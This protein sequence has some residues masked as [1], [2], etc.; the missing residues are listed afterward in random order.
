MEETLKRRKKKASSPAS[1]EGLLVSPSAPAKDLSDAANTF[2]GEGEGEGEPEDPSWRFW[3][4]VTI[5][6]LFNGMFVRTYFSA[7]EFYQSTEVAHFIVFGYGHLTWEWSRMIRGLLHPLVLAALF[8]PLKVLGI[9]YP[10]AIIWVPRIFQSLLL[11][12]QDYAVY[13]LAKLWFSTRIANFSMLL[14][15]GNWFVFYGGV[16][17]FSNSMECVIT[18]ISLIFWSKA[19]EGP[20]FAPCASRWA[21]FFT[22]LCFVMRPTSGILWASVAIAF[23]VSLYRRSSVKEILQWFMTCLVP[24]GGGWFVL[25]MLLDRM[26]YGVFVFVP[27]KFFEFNVVQ[28]LSTFY[29]THVFHW[30]FS[31]GLPVL[32]GSFF[33]LLVVG[34]LLRFRSDLKEHIAVR[35]ILIASMM[36]AVFYSLLAHKEFRFLYPIL[37]VLLIHCALG[38]QFIIDWMQSSEKIRDA[39]LWMRMGKRALVYSGVFA[40]V[41]QI[42]MAVFFSQ[43]HKRGTLDAMDGMRDDILATY[44]SSEHVL[45]DLLVP[46]HHAPFHDH[47][48]LGNVELRMLQCLPPGEGTNGV[49]VPRE[50]YAVLDDFYNMIPRR[51]GIEESDLYVDDEGRLKVYDEVWNSLPHYLMVFEDDLMQTHRDAEAPHNHDDGDDDDSVTVDRLLFELGYRWMNHYFHTPFPDEPHVS[52]NVVVLKKE[53]Q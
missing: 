34:L 14:H 8:Y 16:R 32:L 17:A 23:I 25:S 19:F 1:E 21:L 46:C 27:W 40:L 35:P 30:Y 44:G 52:K 5:F 2:R 9:D 45:V 33:P 3:A 38:F 31:N 41:V 15:L 50:D 26:F 29:G 22:G 39:K 20:S 47:M 28:N 12:L 6:R 10:W 51:L 11:V 36:N 13:R 49:I 43:V 4:A 48:H 7:D 42:G 37:P 53:L 18:T 24:L